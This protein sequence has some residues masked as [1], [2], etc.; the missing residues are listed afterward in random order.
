MPEYTQKMK[1]YEVEIFIRGKGDWSHSH[2]WEITMVWYSNYHHYHSLTFLDSPLLSLE[3][4]TTTAL[5]ARF[6]IVFFVSFSGTLSCITWSRSPALSGYLGCKPNPIINLKLW[7][8]PWKQLPYFFVLF[9][10][11]GLSVIP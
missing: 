9:G 7:F 11:G 1:C 10:C 6:L 2:S 5:T 3:I 4:A 8:W